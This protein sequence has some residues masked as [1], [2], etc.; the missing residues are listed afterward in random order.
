[1]AT[2][3]RDIIRLEG[4]EAAVKAIMRAK[5]N[6]YASDTKRIVHK[7]AGGTYDYWTAD[8]ATGIDPSTVEYSY[9]GWATV[10]NVE[11]ALDTQMKGG[12]WSNVNSGVTGVPVWNNDNRWDEGQAIYSTNGKVYL[13]PSGFT[14]TPLGYEFVISPCK[15][16]DYKYVGC[17]EIG[18]LEYGGYRYETGAMEYQQKAINIFGF[19]GNH[20]AVCADKGEVRL[21]TGSALNSVNGIRLEGFDGCSGLFNAAGSNKFRPLYADENGKVVVAE[22][23]TTHRYKTGTASLVL[24]GTTGT[25]T[26]GYIYWVRDD[27]HVTVT[28][29][30]SM[31]GWG[32]T[33]VTTMTI[34][35]WPLECYPTAR[36]RIP[37]EVYDS[38]TFGSAYGR[39]HLDLQTVGTETGVVCNPLINGANAPEYNSSGWGLNSQRGILRQT[40]TYPIQP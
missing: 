31:L 16:Q 7:W 33:G 38:I 21:R 20:M 39:G 30:P 8:G 37:V 24:S 18:Q 22:S 25:Q 2:T 14:G 27:N 11:Q 3:Y 36:T 29:A 26:G 15:N 32:E 17:H 40:V 13:V 1:V 23:D 34:A 12:Y 10:S 9:I 5:Q 19:T 35:N 6:A 28:F 4:T